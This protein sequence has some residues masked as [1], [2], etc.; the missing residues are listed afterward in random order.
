MKSL[1]IRS[2]RIQFWWQSKIGFLL[3]L[4]YLLL[5]LYNISFSNAIAPLIL[6]LCTSIGFGAVGYYIN[7]YFDIVPDA[8]GAKNNW[9]SKYRFKHHFIV[10][11]FSAMLIVAPWIWLP[12]DKYSALYMCMEVALF[13][14]YAAPPFRWKER[15]VLGIVVDSLYAYTVPFLLAEHTFA[16]VSNHASLLL[17]FAPINLWL[18]IVGI[19][20]IIIHQKKDL[21]SDQLSHTQTW[22]REKATTE[23]TS[24]LNTLRTLETISYVILCGI[25]GSISLHLGITIMVIFFAYLIVVSWSKSNSDF[26]LNYFYEYFFPFIVLLY[27]SFR[28][29]NYCFLLII[30]ALLFGRRFLEDIYLHLKLKFVLSFCINRILFIGFKLFGVDLIRERKSAFS[31]LKWRCK[32][33]KDS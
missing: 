17:I 22:V 4:I 26:H 3:S 6:F 32:S 14:L 7:D 30:H 25:I 19:R 11:L 16:L 5:F 8:I 2:L 21:L 12:L 18:L 29:G 28:D 23:I 13:F 27:L 10:Q 1:I 24:T 33:K 20:N 9:V 15:G 31:Y